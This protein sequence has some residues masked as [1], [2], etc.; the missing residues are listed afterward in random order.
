LQLATDE[1][2]DELDEPLD[3]AALDEEQEK[4]VQREFGRQYQLITRPDRLDEIAAALCRPGL[5]RQGHVRR[6]R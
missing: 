2:K 4:K 5:S 3:E 6:H 1:L